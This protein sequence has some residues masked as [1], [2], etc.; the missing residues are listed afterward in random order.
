MARVLFFWTRKPHIQ[1]PLA[2]RVYRDKSDSHPRVGTRISHFANRNEVRTT[3]RDSQP[4][5]R[6]LGERGRRLHKAS[7]QVQVLGMC[8]K[9]LFGLQLRD[10]DAGYE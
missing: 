4:D 7:Q 2:L 8:R 3:M 5:F 1:Y 9:M 6:A 10:V